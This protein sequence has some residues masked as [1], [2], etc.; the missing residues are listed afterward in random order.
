MNWGDAGRV[1]D[2]SQ[3]WARVEEIRKSA[4][5]E[6]AAIM[7]QVIKAGKAGDFANVIAPAARLQALCVA[8]GGS[9]AEVVDREVLRSTQPE[10]RAGGFAAGTAF[11]TPS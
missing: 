4:G 2:A 8:A 1:D 5:G 7:D 11:G 10:R 9:L 6:V 3:A